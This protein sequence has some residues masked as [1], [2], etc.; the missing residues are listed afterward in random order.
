MQ[1][2]GRVKHDLTACFETAGHLCMRGVALAKRDDLRLRACL[3]NDEH[4]PVVAA[5]EQAADRDP[6][7]VIV[8]PDHN[9][10]FDTLAVAKY[11]GRRSGIDEINDDVDTLLL[12]TEG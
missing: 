9:S 6:E 7:R 3:V 8:L 1:R 4:G 10:H 12:D 2:V 5:A 11:L